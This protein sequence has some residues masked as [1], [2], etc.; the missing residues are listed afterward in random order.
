[1]DLKVF[2]KW[3]EDSENTSLQQVRGMYGEGIFNT[4]DHV[5]EKVFVQC[6]TE[7]HSINVKKF[8]NVF[9]V[10]TS[11]QDFSIND[12]KSYY[13]ILSGKLVCMNLSELEAIPY[14]L[15]E[16]PLNVTSLES[17][18]DMKDVAILCETEEILNVLMEKAKGLG[19]KFGNG[20]YMSPENNYW[21]GEYC[22]CIASGTMGSKSAYKDI[23]VTVIK[24]QKLL[25]DYPFTLL[26]SKLV[27][28]DHKNLIR[29]KIYKINR[30]IPNSYS[31]RYEPILFKYTGDYEGQ[32]N[33]IVHNIIRCENL[34]EEQYTIENSTLGDR[35]AF[36]LA[37]SV[38]REQ[39]RMA[40]IE[41]RRR[42]LLR[43]ELKK[44]NRLNYKHHNEDTTTQLLSSSLHKILVKIK[45]NK[46]AKSLLKL[47]KLG[48]L[49]SST[50]NITI[51]EV[52][53]AMT[54]TPAGKDTVLGKSGKWFK[55][56][57]QEGKYG[58]ILRKV[59]NEQVPSLKY[60]D[61]ELE[62]L[63]NHIKAEASNGDF[64]LVSGEDIRHWY[65]GDRYCTETSTDTLD[66]SC[67]RAESC[68]SYLDI[69]VN[70]PDLVQM[71]I[72][73]KDDRLIGRALLWDGKWMDRIYGSNSTI[74]KFKSFARKKGFHAKDEQSSSNFDR[75]INP[76]TGSSYSEYITFNLE[77][78]FDAYP[79]ADTFCFLNKKEGTL[80][81]EGDEG[82]GLELRSTAGVLCGEETTWD[83]VDGRDID[84]DDAVYLSYRNEN[85]HHNN[86]SECAISGDN[87]LN[88]DM[89]NLPDGRSVYTGV[90]GVFYVDSANRYAT[91]EDVFT[92]GHDDVIYLDTE[93]HEY[94]EE[95]GLT[96]RS[97]SIQT[98]L[99]S[100]GYVYKDSEWVKESDV[101]QTA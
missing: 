6:H 33:Y 99:K 5:L 28:I 67:M 63:V 56:G 10:D 39:E 16:L 90:S 92:C 93:P 3:E 66:S 29:N 52:D 27:G 70:N 21:K 30:P 24:A 26:K 71:V 94:I 59:L 51:R 2:K 89:C 23:G 4:D 42:Y 20:E 76:E 41:E 8:F 58:K 74:T 96:I 35:R 85:T 87:Y 36:R 1:M 69:Y 9:E 25:F 37:L 84:N 100:A 11:N 83:D 81:N 13:G 101:E 46:I 98:A 7:E 45:D 15:H 49:K 14:I 32:Q 65:H 53:T 19:L 47:N 31:G 12:G 73:V 40:R 86:A 82:C 34:L 95:L 44:R 72:L 54:Y 80:T 18:K 78:E 62:Q 79:Y 91:I 75:W 60:T 48:F 22:Y 97:V 17:V 61:H 68:Q 43:R 88:D 77:V 64:Q 57:R 50:R 55:K 38:L